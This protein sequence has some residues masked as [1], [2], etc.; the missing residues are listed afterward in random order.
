[1]KLAN[2]IELWPLE[3]LTPYARNARTHS[4]EQVAKIAA[5][6][7]EFGFNNPIL[8]D[9]SNG[10]IAGHGRMAAAR[11]L[12]LAEA[13]VIV[14]DHLTDAQRRA[15]ILADNR[16]AEDAGWDM[17]L[18]AAEVQD[19]EDEG[20][21]LELAG[22]S[23]DEL[24]ALACDDLLGEKSGT[25]QMQAEQ[26]PGQSEN[27]AEG[28]E[29][30]AQEQQHP[31]EGAAQGGPAPAEIPE[32]ADQEPEDRDYTVT[33]PGD[34]WVLGPHRVMCGDS[35]NAKDVAQLMA[36]RR[37]N[38]MHADPPYGMGKEADGVAN[39]NLRG[40]KLDGFQLD[41]WGAFRPHLV[42]NASAY[43]WGNAPDL[44][45][46]WYRA[47]LADTEPM[48]LKNEIVWDKKAIAG[49]ASPDLTQFPEATERCLFFV[50][51]RYVLLIN[52]TKEDY[53]P[54]W[55]SIRTWMCEQRD[56]AGWKA[57]DVK[58]ICGN[59]MYGHWF[60]T[61][62]WSVINRENYEKLQAA[63]QG[64][65]FTRSYD[66][67]HAEYKRLQA[68]YNGEVADDLRAE[69]RAARPYFDNAHEIMRDVWEFPRVVGEERHGHATPK[70]VAM[71]VRAIKSASREGELVVEPFGGSGSTPIGAEVCGRACFTMEMQ[72]HYCDVI[73]RRWAKLTGRQ[74]VLEATGETFETVEALRAPAN[75]NEAT[76]AAA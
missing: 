25:D 11:K 23:E 6:I 71:M 60:G 12:G 35:T 21:D 59:H 44:W 1:M 53:W 40:E 75:D 66:D 9:S 38:L 8:V 14:L 28:A 68:I 15:Y 13:P 57:A 58:E 5:S 51:G 27:T 29:S 65:A 20:F 31:Q 54:G 16:L 41:W 56:L 73:V 62:Q 48:T 46:L 45:R 17:E 47:G 39:D 42:S 4:P 32:G 52:Q 24:A 10:I 63:A 3:R 37:A 61:S 74:A 26:L 2:R 34:V 76:E 30:G 67:L 70:P 19:L 64:Q 36:G 55:D 49:M 33:R 50:L 72:A 7:A 22:F 69:F 18:L 43:I